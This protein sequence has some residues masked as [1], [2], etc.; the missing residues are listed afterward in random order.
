VVSGIW[1]WFIFGG[2]ALVGLVGT[3]VIPGLR[4]RQAASRSLARFAAAASGVRVTAVGT[5]N[6]PRVGSIVAV[7]N[8]STYL[9]AIVLMAALRLDLVFIAKSE[10]AE[11]WLMRRLLTAVGTRFVERFDAARS[12]EDAHN[13]TEAARSGTSFAFF[14]EGTFVRAP[15]LL[16]FRMGAFA[17]AAESGIPVVPIAI[18]GT[19]ALMPAGD[20]LPRRGPVQVVV[21]APITPSGSDWDAA[22]RLRNAARTHILAHCGEPDLAGARIATVLR[23]DS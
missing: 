23:T 18:A 19:R 21:G 8:H 10:L 1:A 4:A 9:D 7:A 2:I 22:I 3:Y 11:N 6:L 5:E 20:W 12:A 15:G 16:E 13:L 14:P 17:L